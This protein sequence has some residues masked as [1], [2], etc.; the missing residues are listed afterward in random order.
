MN[1]RPNKKI[2]Y[3]TY[4]SKKKNKTYDKLLEAIKRY[5]SDRIEKIHKKAKD[6]GA[7]FRILSGFFGLI[8]PYEKIP[9]YDFLLV[10]DE[11]KERLNSILIKQLSQLKKK[12]IN[13]IKYQTENL[14]MNQSIQQYYKVIRDAAKEL[15][16]KLETVIIQNQS[17]ELQK[18][19]KGVIN[20]I[21][22][23]L[24]KDKILLS[25]D[26]NERSITHKLAEYLQNEF[27]N[28]NVDCEYNRFYDEGKKLELPRELGDLIDFSDINWD[29]LEAKTIF[30][31]IIIHK[32][33]TN[34]NYLVI[35]LKKWTNRSSRMND[36]IKLKAFTTKPFSYEFGMF[37]ELLNE[38]KVS[39]T[40]FTNGN[41]GESIIMN[42]PLS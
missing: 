17:D 30:P 28:F 23:L 32:R 6:E 19:K 16:I 3:I 18:I 40:L 38:K 42:S 35:E 11:E 8:S 13:I 15:K 5:K 24:A 7:E 33:N 9:Y 20:S 31:D 37:I 25:L 21:Q 26:V 14:L 36:E 34:V 29:D 4:C 2:L 12:G 27:P 39:F 10:G 22:K 1:E 41:K